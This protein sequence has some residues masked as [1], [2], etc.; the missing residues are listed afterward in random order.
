[1]ND[2]MSFM[3]TIIICL[4]IAWGITGNN[5]AKT[6]RFI[7]NGYCQILSTSENKCDTEIIWTKCKENK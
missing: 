6:K 4:L 1:M 5:N 7:E 3:V 2:L